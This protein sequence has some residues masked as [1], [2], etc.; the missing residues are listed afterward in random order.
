MSDYL[1][2]ACRRTFLAAAFLA[3]ALG[4]P[5]L[6]EGAPGVGKT[7]AGRSLAAVLGRELIRLQCYEGLDASGALYEW[8]YARQMLAIRR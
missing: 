6:L 8:N 1:S 5:L 3:L 4:K 7:E 2:S